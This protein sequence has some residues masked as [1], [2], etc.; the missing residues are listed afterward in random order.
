M[1][2]IRSG[3]QLLAPAVLL[4]LAVGCSGPGTGSGSGS[5]RTG[6]Q[7][8]VFAASSLTDVISTINEAY[9][10]G[11]QLRINLGSSAQLT[12]QLRS[13][14]PADVLITADLE[15]LQAVRDEGLLG[16]EQVIAGNTSVL[17]VA[18][19]NPGKVHALADVAQ[20]SV[21]VALCAPSVPCGR[22]AERV[23]AAAGV[24]VSG[25]SRE[26]SVRSVLTKVATGQAD[27]GLV[28][29][30]DALSAANQGVT[31]LEV[32]DPEPNQYPAALTA[33][34]AE[35]EAAV[36]FYEWLAGEEA[37]RILRSA[38]FQPAGT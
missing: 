30:S 29:Q 1:R 27:A 23:L 12:A 28:Y 13:G 21:Q 26:D 32:T 22:A 6:Q 16:A 3:R 10:G 18:P 2:R 37:A 8:T 11:G 35:H 31:Y 14:A 25:E 5:D 7:I 38:G 24:M 9:D 17:A 36:R 15:A 19:G 4:V 20:E 34:G 33:E